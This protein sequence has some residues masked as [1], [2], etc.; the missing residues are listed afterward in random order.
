MSGILFLHS[1]DLVL[2]TGERGN[3]LCLYPES[4][5]LVLVF[6][7]SKE[8]PHCDK[9][10]TLFKQLPSNV[11]GCTFAIFNVTLNMDIVERSRNTIAPITY[12]P[13]LILYVNGSPFMRYDGDHSIQSIQSF[14]QDIYNKLQ[15]TRFAPSP[16]SQSHSQQ[17]H[18]QQ[19]H[20]Q[21]SHSQQSHSQQQHPYQPQQ[22]TYSNS[23]SLLSNQTQEGDG[24]YPPK[25]KIPEYTIGV[26]V[27]SDQKCYLSFN[28]AYGK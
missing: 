27:C 23:N 5:G 22:Q 28:T 7:Y 19:S 10:M 16:A 15:K 24:L 13:D 26:P 9:V 20:S 1:N 18:S 6:Y 12:V 17:S 14:L 21:Q 4:Q 8:C 3:M 11:T 2:K 25:M